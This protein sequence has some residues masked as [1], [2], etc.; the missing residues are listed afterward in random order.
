MTTG[1]IN[2]VSPVMSG[3]PRGQVPRERPNTP[4]KRLCLS[5]NTLRIRPS[6]CLGSGH[7]DN[8]EYHTGFPD[9]KHDTLIT[10]GAR[11]RGSCDSV[12]IAGFVAF[13]S[14]PEGIS[15]ADHRDRRRE[16]PTA[17]SS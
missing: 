14:Y 10:D 12:A 16:S 15:S 5:T 2:Q 8:A 7:R 9:R 3:L 17:T 4:P 11:L 1:R 13:E 6:N